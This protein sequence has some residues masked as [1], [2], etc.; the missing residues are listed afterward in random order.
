MNTPQP[1]EYTTVYN[2]FLIT[3]WISGFVNTYRIFDICAVLEAQGL[4]QISEIDS[5]SQSHNQHGQIQTEPFTS[6]MQGC[7]CRGVMHR[8]L[9]G[10]FGARLNRDC[11]SIYLLCLQKGAQM[12]PCTPLYNQT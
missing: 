1:K 4:P 12:V 11:S 2:E 9:H 8:K 3:C 6:A 5:I 10:C 7:L